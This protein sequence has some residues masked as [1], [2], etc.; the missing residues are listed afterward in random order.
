ML[1]IFPINHKKPKTK[2]SHQLAITLLPL[3][4][5]NL[6][7][8]CLPATEVSRANVVACGQATERLP[9]DDVEDLCKNVA[10]GIHGSR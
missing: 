2:F 6:L 10:A 8:A 3:C 5:L 4:A 1:G 9:M 7:L